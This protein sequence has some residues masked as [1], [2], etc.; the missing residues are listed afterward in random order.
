[1]SGGEHHKT[2]LS[3][4]RGSFDRGACE[5]KKKLRYNLSICIFFSSMTFTFFQFRSCR[6]VPEPSR[7]GWRFCLLFTFSHLPSRYAN[8]DENL[9]FFSAT[10]MNVA[11]DPNMANRLF[12]AG[13]MTSLR[14]WIGVCRT[15]LQ[16]L[17]VLARTA[18]NYWSSSSQHSDDRT[19]Y[20]R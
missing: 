19:R 16:P 12:A 6:D 3:L 2:V 1:M 15:S 14:N 10:K 11:H 8:I 17:G 20:K 4:H 5:E 7:W 18:V 9:F 13:C